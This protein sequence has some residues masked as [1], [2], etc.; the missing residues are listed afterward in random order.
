[1]KVGASGKVASGSKKIRNFSVKGRAPRFT[2]AG[3]V[4]VPVPLTQAK[5]SEERAA[6]N[7]AIAARKHELSHLPSL[8]S[9][10][11]LRD[12]YWE[13]GAGYNS[14]PNEEA[15][16]VLKGSSQLDISHAGGELRA[17]LDELAGCPPL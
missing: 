4:E 15:A 9:I 17:V 16:N 8:P 1:M 7:Q 10:Y 5:R 13:H 11:E 14:D 6:T 12:S 2:A 3:R